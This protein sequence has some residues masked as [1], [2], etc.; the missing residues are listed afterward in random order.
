VKAQLNLLSEFNVNKLE[1]KLKFGARAV[2]SE[3]CMTEK[4]DFYGRHLTVDMVRCGVD[5]D[6]ANLVKQHMT[7]AIERIGATILGV[8]E[9]KFEPQGLTQVFLLSESH[10]SVH[11]YPEFRSCFVDIFTCGSTID[12]M[13]FAEILRQAWRPE[14]I[15]TTYSERFSPVWLDR[16]R[17]PSGVDT[18]E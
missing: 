2:F 9:H 15:K 11:T 10:A 4:F 14:G 18:V 12:V 17:L 16:E 8:L 5:L 7:G 1:F 13:P 6:D 3:H